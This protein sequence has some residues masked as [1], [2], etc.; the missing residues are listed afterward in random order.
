[1]PFHAIARSSALGERESEGE[2]SEE[3]WR[4]R[5]RRADPVTYV[6]ERI[7]ADLLHARLI[8]WSSPPNP[9]ELDE[10]SVSSMPPPGV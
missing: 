1:M 3:R 5:T 10:K 6:Q 9:V 8:Q 2:R 4:V 7:K